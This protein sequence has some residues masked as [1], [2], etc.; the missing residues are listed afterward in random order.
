MEVN[1]MDSTLR[2]FTQVLIYMAQGCGCGEYCTEAGM[3]AR[4]IL[5]IHGVSWK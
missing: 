2:E 1:E 5:A 4:K 3:M